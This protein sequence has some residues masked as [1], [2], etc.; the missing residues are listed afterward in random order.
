[1]D[2]AIVDSLRSI[3]GC[4]V[5]I[6]IVAKKKRNSPSQL[7][8]APL[9][10]VVFEIRWQ[11]KADNA[12]SLLWN[13]PGY[14]ILAENF[15]DAAAARGFN[16][17]KRPSYGGLMAPYSV[18]LRF[19]KDEALPFPIWQIG[20]GIFAA[21]DSAGYEW[22]S[23][24]TLAV[25]GAK[26]LLS[27]YP[28]MKTFKLQPTLLELRYIDSI[29][30]SL[31]AHQ[32]VLRFLNEQTSMN[33]ELSSF[34]KKK[35]LGKLSSASLDFSFA[36]SGLRDTAFNVRVGNARIENKETII[37][38][39]KVLTKSAKIIGGDTMSTQLQ[40][41][42]EWLDKAHGVTSPFFNQFVSPSLMEQFKVPPNI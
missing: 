21:N 40:F 29:D 13:D 41:I 2:L 26:A 36:V 8:N 18:L 31:I 22:N 25:N 28:K 6:K 20:P 16:A 1:M 32:D 35:P 4:Y 11:L 30:K 24:R 19:H 14:P 9:A 34:L 39:S 5:S 23:F 42:G 15:T 33:V 3:T 37:L 27:S 12:P 10:E 7:P 38:T 17:I